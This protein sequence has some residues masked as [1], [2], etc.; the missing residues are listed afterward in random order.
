MMRHSS[1]SFE[2]G[3]KGACAHFLSLCRDYLP[4]CPIC[5]VVHYPST[6]L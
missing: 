5:L 3:Q 1:G 2:R 4:A 6:Y